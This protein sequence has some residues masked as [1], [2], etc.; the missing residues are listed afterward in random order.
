MIPPEMELQKDILKIEDLIACCYDEVE[1]IKLQEELTA[2][3]LRFQQVMERERLK[4]VQLFVCI[5]IKY[6]VNYAKRDKM[7]TFKT[8]EELAT[9]IEEQQL[10][11]LFIKTENC[12]V[13]DVMLRKVNYVLENYN[14]VEKIEILLQDM[15]EIAG[16]YA[17]FTGPTVLLFYNGKEILRESRFISLENLENHSIIRGIRE[18][19]IWNLLFSYY[20]L[21]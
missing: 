13:C 4:I 17:V 7:N 11:L 19:F 9:Y 8:I 18:A 14:Y 5:K 20:Y 2:K 10:V 16:R 21:L 12:G 1:R 6:F 3:T 15:Q